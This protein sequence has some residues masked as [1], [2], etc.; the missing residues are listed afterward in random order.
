[1]TD[2]LRA[3]GNSTQSSP[4]A[5]V[6]RQNVAKSDVSAA[7][8][9]AFF[10]SGDP[11]ASSQE[12]SLLPSAHEDTQFPSRADSASIESG[13][14]EPKPTRVVQDVTIEPSAPPP[15]PPQTDTEGGQDPDLIQA[16]PPQGRR[17]ARASGQLCLTPYRADSA[18]G[19]IGRTTFATSGRHADTAARGPTRIAPSRHPST[20]GDNRKQAGSSH[21]RFAVVSG[22]RALR[23]EGGKR[24]RNVRCITGR[25][26]AQRR[27]S[28][29]CRKTD[30]TCVRCIFNPRKSDGQE[31]R[32]QRSAGSTN[33]V[34]AH[35]HGRRP[36]R[37]NAKGR[38]CCHRPTQLVRGFSAL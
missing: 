25:R 9:Q 8:W 38:P 37:A 22:P 24:T 26:S 7:F 28:I 34:S 32:P 2:L 30:P 23:T 13:E 16:A 14:P 6:V 36:L 35:Q 10:G 1:M 17:R 33:Q 19:H 31:P 27:D 11:A 15:I 18:V 4:A 3:I 20:S 21:T 12:K 5:S 29:H